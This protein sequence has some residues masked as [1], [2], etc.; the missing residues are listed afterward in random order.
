MWSGVETRQE[1]EQ[2]VHQIHELRIEE[3]RHRGDAKHKKE[4]KAEKKKRR[5]LMSTY[6]ATHK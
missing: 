2:N 3:R 1:V 6:F 5:E 4:K